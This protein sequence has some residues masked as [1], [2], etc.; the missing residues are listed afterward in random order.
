VGPSFGIDPAKLA[1][2]A[3]SLAG[4]VSSL[5]IDPAKLAA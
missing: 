4:A 3:A 5:G 2:W 1:A